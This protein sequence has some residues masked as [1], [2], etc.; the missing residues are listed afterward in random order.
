MFRIELKR[1][2][3]AF[4][5]LMSFIIVSIGINIA[6]KDTILSLYKTTLSYDKNIDI[7]YGPFKDLVKNEM[8]EMVKGNTSVYFWSRLISKD[9][10][11]FVFIL[12]I[13]FG[14]SE[15]SSGRNDKTFYH[16]L[17]FIDRNTLYHSKKSASYF[18]IFLATAVT[19]IFSL[20]YLSSAGR[21]VAAGGL[22]LAFPQMFLS[23]M[24]LY[25]ILSG[26]S[27]WIGNQFLNKITL[28]TII[29]AVSFMII[30]GLVFM[31]SSGIFHFIT[32]QDILLNGKWNPL[33]YVITIAGSLVLYI[34]NWKLFRKIS[35]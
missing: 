19:L 21:T 6:M 33:G 24:L 8:E 18:Y 11:R 10:L 29:T 1:K 30:S 27:I 31:L 32:G 23:F 2:W 9:F 26:V 13:I 22:S 16:Y 5:V 34:T 20:V 3:I 15:F 35:I 25:E 28:I 12:I 7:F 4:F 14:I 17:N